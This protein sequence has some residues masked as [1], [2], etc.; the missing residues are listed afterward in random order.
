MTN[1]FKEEI[2]D[3]LK[4]KIVQFEGQYI[5]GCDFCHELTLDENNAGCWVMYISEAD[6]FVEKY[7]E[8]AE[9]TLKYYRNDFGDDFI[10]ERLGLGEFTEWDEY[11]DDYDEDDDDIDRVI[12]NNKSEVFTFFMLYYGVGALMSELDCVS[13]IWNNR[14]EITPEF[15]ER[16]IDELSQC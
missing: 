15:I 3:F 16:F 4:E 1:G 2:I 14:T 13:E 10:D 11:G 12:K 9:E 5:C 8:D 7:R 6:N